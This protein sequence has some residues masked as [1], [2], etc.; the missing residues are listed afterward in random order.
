MS[1]ILISQRAINLSNTLEL[2]DG[3]ITPEVEQQ[4]LDLTNC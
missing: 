4:M 3:E 1:N 2:L